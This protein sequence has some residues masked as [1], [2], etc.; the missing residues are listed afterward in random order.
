MLKNSRKTK[1]NVNRQTDGRTDVVPNVIYSSY[2]MSKNI[3]MCA[4]MFKPLCFA[5]KYM[6]MKNQENNFITSQTRDNQL[7]HRHS[8]T[9]Q[10]RDNQLWH[11]HWTTSQTR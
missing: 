4:S 9:S 7:W 8:T 6:Y 11:R 5:S 1:R 10:T 2:E 3:K